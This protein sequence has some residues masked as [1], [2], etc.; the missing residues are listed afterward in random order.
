MMTAISDTLIKETY[1]ASSC[2][3]GNHYANH[4]EWQFSMARKALISM[5]IP[6]NASILDIGCGD[7]RFTKYF[8]STI[9]DGTVIG[10]DPNP[11]MLAAAQ[12]NTLPNLSFVLGNA[13]N[14]P[15]KNKFDRIVAFNSLHWVSETELALKEVRD[16][17]LPG[18][19]VLILV[20]PVQVRSPL[21]QIVNAV[22]MQ[23]KWNIYFTNI[24]NLFSFHT[25]AE[26]A[27]FLEE[28]GLIP[29]N[30]H[31]MDGSFKYKDREAFLDSIAAWV[32]FGNIPEAKRREYV[33]DIVE[34][35]LEAIPPGPNGE[36]Y[37]LLDELVIL[38][39]KP[40]I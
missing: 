6:A 35:Y 27:S 33:Y 16:A 21:H 10:L 26:W 34:S 36:V 37:Y 2:W 19:Q 29:E 8:S 9:P 7:G 14:L 17:L 38:A 40:F 22:A 5:Q 3:N 30:L 23:D 13:E 11:S 32:P 1:I 24:R 31:L 12:T 15:F 39:S 18:G 4:S 25:L 28:V 20:V